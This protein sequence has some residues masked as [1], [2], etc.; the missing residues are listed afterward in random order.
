MAAET[1]ETFYMKQELFKISQILG[2]PYEKNYSDRL[3]TRFKFDE[4]IYDFKFLKLDQYVNSLQNLSILTNE[5]FIEFAIEI[6][7]V[8]NEPIF[9]GTRDLMKIM[10]VEESVNR[11][12]NMFPC[13]KKQDPKLELLENHP[14]VIEFYNLEENDDIERKLSVIRKAYL[15]RDEI[16]G[17]TDEDTMNQLQKIQK[18]HEIPPEKYNK[19]LN[20]RCKEEFYFYLTLDELE[21]LGW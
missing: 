21:T 3:E 19:L 7:P 11:L 15:T 10:L 5:E 8:C 14:S 17:T 1:F 18:Y 6:L 4:L 9:G 13:S 2:S 20:H 16:L 12:K